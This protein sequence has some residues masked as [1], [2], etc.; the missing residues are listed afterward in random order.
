MFCNRCNRVYSYLGI[1]QNSILRHIVELYCT[2]MYKFH[3]YLK[4]WSFGTNEMVAIECRLWFNLRGMIL[5]Y[6]E[7]P[8]CDISHLELNMASKC[9]ILML[10]GRRLCLTHTLFISPKSGASSLIYPSYIMYVH[11]SNP[12]IKKQ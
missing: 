8:K 4:V 3:K 11:P 10:H 6:I 9:W 2:Y 12:Q 7:I 5:Q 1:I